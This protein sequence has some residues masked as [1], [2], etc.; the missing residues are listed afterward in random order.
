M[1]SCL[2]ISGGAA[3]VWPTWDHTSGSS[4]GGWAATLWYQKNNWFEWSAQLW[5]C[6]HSAPV[7]CHCKE[8]SVWGLDQKGLRNWTSSEGL[9]EAVMRWWVEAGYYAGREMLS[10]NPLDMEDVPLCSDHQMWHWFKSCCELSGCDYLDIISKG[11]IC[12]PVLPLHLPAS[13]TGWVTQ[14][15]QLGTEWMVIQVGTGTS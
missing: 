7:Y 12:L 13:G 9:W 11:P 14:V 8:W 10:W 4:S 15:M 1:G 3:G 5:L 2:V 6:S